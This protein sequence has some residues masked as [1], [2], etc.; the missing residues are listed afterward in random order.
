MSPFITDVVKAMTWGNTNSVTFSTVLCGAR[1]ARRFRSGEALHH[2]SDEP[3]CQGLFRHSRRQLSDQAFC[4]SGRKSRFSSG[5]DGF[6]EGFDET[7]PSSWRPWTPP[8]S[9]V[10]EPNGESLGPL[11]NRVPL[12]IVWLRANRW[13]TA[14]R[15]TTWPSW[16]PRSRS[17]VPAVSQRGRRGDHGHAEKRRRRRP[18]PPGH[19]RGSTPL[20]CSPSPGASTWPRGRGAISTPSMPTPSRRFGSSTISW[21]GT[22]R[23]Y[24]AGDL[25]S[26]VRTRLRTL[27]SE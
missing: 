23:P 22:H 18:R 7:R 17:R 3:S 8:R 13:S 15:W 16:S 27:Q 5:D 24:A 11:P 10:F 6:D 12:V 26:G 21:S 9:D 14:S 20:G 25:L 19:H 1:G 2:R 4:G